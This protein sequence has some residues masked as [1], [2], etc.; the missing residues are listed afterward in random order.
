[1]VK[2]Y[3]CGTCGK[4]FKQ[5]GH[6][7]NHL[8]RKR[9]C[10]PIENKVIEKQIQKKLQ[11]LSD[12]GD[13]TIVNKNLISSIENNT[14]TIE[15]SEKKFKF[16][17]LF[18]GIGGFH[19][20]L[21]KLNCECIIA[22]DIDKACRENYKLNYSIEPHPDIRKINPDD[23][24]ETVDIICGGFPCQAFSNAGKKKMFDD[25]RGLLFDEIIRLAKVKK[26]KFMF[27]ENVKHI[28]KVGDKQV[29]EYIKQK[30]HENDY[31]LQLF[32]ISPHHYGVPQQ[33][34]RVYFVCVRNDIY[35][36]SDIVLPPKVK[37]FKFEDFLDK[38]DEIDPK[39]FIDGDVLQCLNA[40]EEMIKIFPPG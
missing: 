1:M 35:N 7:T 11:E 20:A 5:K 34:D 26:P 30:L 24:G 19:Q 37:D 36:G 10:K 18:C 31:H 15:M 25:D 6:Y 40:W 29:I 12:K 28:L 33:R 16:I 38:K 32:E 3:I 14:E 2:Q 21:N 13:I 27:L 17:D 4:V 39:Y 8:N 9:P 22:C 23:I